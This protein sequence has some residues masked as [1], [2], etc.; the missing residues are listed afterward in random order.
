MTGVKS[1]VEKHRS[2]EETSL[3]H[4]HLQTL[5]AAAHPARVAVGKEPTSRLY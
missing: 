3:S 2:Q 4:A 1:R 5:V